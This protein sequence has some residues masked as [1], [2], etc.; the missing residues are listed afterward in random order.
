MTNCSVSSV[1]LGVLCYRT[2][3][4]LF[5]DMEEMAADG[6]EFEMT[7]ITVRRVPMRVFKNAPPTMRAFWDNRRVRRPS[8]SSTKMSVSL[9]PGLRHRFVR[10]H[11]L[12]TPTRE[13][14]RSVTPMRNFRVGDDVLGNGVLGAA[15]VGMNAW[16]M[17]EMKFGPTRSAEG[18]DRHMNA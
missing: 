5:V 6:S 9:T 7:D 15:V 16:W 10:R 1:K 11:H 3:A 14:W 13:R 18:G 17:K 4:A 12:E 8:T 2:D